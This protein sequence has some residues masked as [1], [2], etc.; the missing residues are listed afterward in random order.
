MKIRFVL[1]CVVL[2]L[3]AQ[4]PQVTAQNFIGTNAP[5]AGTN[6]N[7]NVGVAATNLSLVISNSANTYS[8][9]LLKRGG[10]PTDTDFDFVSRVSGRTNHINL[11]LPEF[12]TPTNYGL[13]VLTPGTSTTH[14]FNVR[15]TT[16]RTDLRSAAYPALKPLAFSTTGTLTN[17]GGGH[18]HYFQVDVPTNLSTGWRIVV[19]A[20][21][22][23]NPDV[24][25]RRNE[26]PTTGTYDKGSISQTIDTITF[27]DAEATAGTY[28]IGVF[29]PAAAPGNTTYT[30][31]TEANYLTTLTW[32]PGATH[33]GTQIFT[34][35]SPTGGDYFFKI[36]TQ[37]SAV[38]AWRTALNVISGEADVYLR[39]GAFEPNPDSYSRSSTRVGS[40]GF[41]LHSTEYTAA[42]T[43]YIAVRATPGAQWRLMTGDVFVQQLGT[44]AADAS[45]GSG[46]VPIGPEGIRFFRTT[47]TVDTLAWR[48]WLNGATN[49]I[50]IE[51]TAV[52]H[53][54][55][56]SW[57]DLHQVRQ[58]LIVP[59]YLVG[60]D[61]YFLCVPGN[62]GTVINLDSR[63][64]GITDVPFIASTNFTVTG[65]GYVTY[66]I[67]VP[68][69]QIAWLSAVAPS[70]GNANLSLRRDSVPNE[71][72]NDAYSE[73]AGTVTDS[74]SLVPP[75]LSDGTFYVTIWGDA[76][77]TCTFT[78]G[79]PVITPVSYV[80]TILN[81]DVNRVGWRY[82]VVSNIAE[83]LG[84]LGWDLV[85]SNQPPGTEIAL[86]QNAVPG[87]WN[88][89]G[90]DG[91]SSGTQ[92][93]L[94]QSGPDGFIQRP[95]HQ[96]DIYYIGVYH[97]STA[98]GP[99][100]L[101]LRQLSA[102]DL[103]FDNASLSRT[104]ILGTRWQFF[105][106]IVP[107]P[108]TAGLG[109][110]IRLNS[111]TTGQPQLVIARDVLPV[112]L[113][114]SGW[115]FPQHSLT[116]PSGNHLAASTDWTR[117]SYDSSGTINEDG[118]I[119]QVGMN[120]PLEP[121]TYYVGVRAPNGN[122]PMTYSLLSRGIGGGFTI[123][124]TPLAF[125][126]GS[127]TNNSLAARQ[128]AYY[129]VTIASNTPSWKVRLR[130]TSGESLLLALRNAL[131]GVMSSA[132]VA[133]DNADG[134]KM[135]KLGNEH[136]L[137]LPPNGQSSL[138]AGTY[139][140]AV[141]SEGQNPGDNTIGT[142]TSAY[143]LTSLGP[144]PVAN[145][146]TLSVADLTQG[147]ALQGGEAA[148]YQ[149]TVAGGVPAFEVTLEN[150]TGNP[151]VNLLAGTNLPFAPDAYGGEGG[152]NG[153]NIDEFIV[154]TVNPPT[155]GVYSLIV[156]AAY[157]N[158]GY[159]NAT[160][161]L[162]VHRVNPPV[163][164]ADGGL[165]PIANQGGG[166]YRY[167][168]VDI[169]AGVLGWDLRLT[170][171][172]TVASPGDNN[173]RILVRRDL[174]PEGSGNFHWIFP[175]N[176]TEW[177]SGY[178]WGSYTDW[179][180]RGYDFTGLTN[181]I[182][183]IF[184]VGT[185]RPLEAGT[186]YVGVINF[187]PNPTNTISYT[188]SSR[189]IGTNTTIRVTDLAFN[190][191]SATT[192]HP[193]R[194]VA[195]Y[196]VNIP[197]N[198][199]SWKVRVSTNNGEALLLVLKGAIP[200]FASRED[201]VGGAG[202]SG[203][204]MQK[205]GNEYF[206][207]LP[208]QGDTNLPAGTYYL[209]VV[210]EGR[211]PPS[212]NNVGTNTTS[213]TITSLGTMPVV[214]LGTAGGADLVQAGALPGGDLAAYQFTVPPGT[215][216]LEV[217]LE[218]RTGTPFMA[219]VAGDRLPAPYDSYGAEGGQSSSVVTG[220]EL[221]N[222]A[223]PAPGVF[224][225]LVKATS[226]GGYPDA[227]YTV[228]VVSGGAA[229]LAFDGGTLSVTNQE[230]DTLRYFLVTVPP[231]AA[232]WSL[233]LINVPSDGGEP[234]MI[235]SR[236]VLPD[237][238]AGNTP[239]LYPQ[240]DTVWHPGY[241]WRLGSDWTG[242]NHSSD[243]QVQVGQV[244]AVG[245][246]GPLSPGQYYVGV[247]NYSQDIPMTYTIQSRGIGAGYT[248]PIT[249]LAFSNG[250]AN[251]PALAPREAAYFRVT[252][253]SNAPSWKVRLNATAGE[254]LL[255]INQGRIPTHAAGDYE[256]VSP[257]AGKTM[258]S[259]GNEHFFYRPAGGT[260]NL[261]A[262]DYFLAVVSEGNN[263]ANSTLIGT[264]NISATL[265]SEGPAPVTQLGT[266]TGADLV[267]PGALEG[268]ESR[269]YQFT[270]PPDKLGFNIRLEN[271]VGHPLFFFRLGTELPA[272]SGYYYGEDGGYNAGTITDPAYYPV[273]GPTP[274]VYSLVVKAETLGG[275]FPNASYTLRIAE[276]PITNLNF[277]S[278]LNTNGLSNVAT[279]LLAENERRYYRVQVPATN[280]GQ[281]VL[282]WR[283]Q[284]DWTSGRADIRVRKDLLPTDGLL[285]M[286]F[287][288]GG[289]AAIV[290]PMLTPGTWYVEVKGNGSTAYTLTNSQLLIERPAWNLPMLGQLANT[291]G[292]THPNFADTGVGTNGVPLPGDQG[293]DLARGSFHYYTV[294]VPATNGGL[295]RVFLEAISG[296]PDLYA[297]VGNPP[298]LSHYGSDGG[299]FG[300][301]LYDR[302][303]TA[304][305]TE[306][307]N[308][309]PIQGRY[310]RW[311]PPGTWY[312]AVYADGNSNVRYR[313]RLSVGDVQ[314]LTLSGGNL[315]NQT[316]AA[317]DWR[318]YRVQIPLNS[319]RSWNVTFSQVVGDVLMHVRD[320][321]PPG[322]RES[323]GYYVS[324]S[325]DDKNHGPYPIVDSPGTTNFACPP[326]RPGNAYYLGFRAVNDATFSVS[327]AISGG[328]IDVTNTIAFYGGTTTNNLPPNGV[329]KYRIDVPG[330]ATRWKHRSTNA[331][332][333]LLH[334]DQGSYPTLTSADH[335]RSSGN[336]NAT[337]NQALSTNGWPWQP[338]H[339]YFL[340]VTNTSGITQP[341]YFA[342]DGK[343]CATDDDDNDSLLD[344]WELTYWQY[345]YNHD[346]DDDPDLDGSNNL[347]E[348]NDGTNP[349]NAASFLA[350]LVI[351]AAAGT[352]SR[353]PNQNS[354]VPGTPVTLT[355]TPGPGGSFFGWSGD[356][357]GTNNPLVLV[358]NTHKTVTAL[359]GVN[360]SL[361][362]ADY[363]FQ[364]SLTS[365]VGTAPALQN[366][367][368]G[369]AF[370]TDTVD[371]FSRTVYRWP[372]HN[373][374]LL[375]PAS[376]VI[377]SN[378]WSM[379][380]LFRFDDVSGY[381]RVLDTKNPP[382]ETG[383]YIFDGNLNFY[384]LGSGSGSPI[385]AN[386]YVQVVLT[387]DEAKVIR[388]YVNGVLQFTTSAD[389]ANEGLLAGSPQTLRFFV[390]NA[391][392][393]GAGA[394]ARIRLYDG[395]IQPGQVT[396][397]DRLP[398]I[399][400]GGP[401][402][403]L[404]N[405][406]FTANGRAYF[407]I[408]GTVG[409]TFVIERNT[410][411]ATL[412][413]TTL[414]NVTSFS[415]S[416][417]FTSP[418]PP[419]PQQYFRA[420]VP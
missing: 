167:F 23:G 254:S 394:V 46:A 239:W 83:Q 337:L 177:T 374:L 387:R 170:N 361:P 418:P 397:L 32:D 66:R 419:L 224:S 247:I 50:L 211:N 181:E 96:A 391:G 335:W 249:P 383:L 93:H 142:G 310:E 17:G 368:A 264:G 301:Y 356:A 265:T 90:N 29:L 350:Q 14:T 299:Y 187:N 351:N 98:L 79:N 263:P 195:Y 51:K 366:V 256:V 151:I 358:M 77:Y 346:S 277:D 154:S 45:S 376:G 192:N 215:L 119:L 380:F 75:T 155:N 6:F 40:D 62:P 2:L 110:D 122:A 113:N 186:Y 347:T 48:L 329:L 270:I 241:Q 235:V 53:P 163:L 94:D 212:A 180:G 216:N 233:R 292:V 378:V 200:S 144:L 268:G 336:A 317:G 252:V 60:G 354:Y 134:L 54:G 138:I 55:S 328:N 176:H 345:T 97:P 355:A 132:L 298:T 114:S 276:A 26:L 193:P 57:Y 129:A 3:V 312:F 121:G 363:R 400:P 218:N 395:V 207:L 160:Y 365:S 69:Q 314:N 370:Q 173:H 108:A 408:I 5:G 245:M 183:R 76:N 71:G 203:R 102:T 64:Q 63:K 91:G 238:A 70:S 65:Y 190:G 82:F 343:N 236:D 404:L 324:W 156:K 375:S 278:A 294:N 27:T 8:Y 403:R 179:T 244:F 208:P 327:S 127:H 261:P 125:N 221:I 229:N 325:D 414:S 300:P 323:A 52:P 95:G 243:G 84:S 10:T 369:N 150:R 364:N 198:T 92:G 234:Q 169:P 16:N 157:G 275:D 175:Q 246:N 153:G 213:F 35:N 237:G 342:M 80:S 128:V 202:A 399:A 146:G 266:L 319:P 117:R 318:Y 7:F 13:R 126:G 196:R 166:S 240:Y 227:T 159:S 184:A 306:Y 231:N 105:K 330:D 165:A 398:G 24:F 390:D 340:V 143:E 149:F 86:R 217:R 124:V 85:L 377:S 333:V 43:W 413:W 210:S 411:L 320:V 305:G 135:Q 139:Y 326:L 401:V 38:G 396:Q 338:G 341:F 410:N 171:I 204:K 288:T 389:T 259:S 220:P 412:N 344:C 118:R 257:G 253:P 402:L 136:F 9:L 161:T 262:G 185:G 37:S 281:A 359:F 73:V 258:R 1:H 225:L 420:R 18:W 33:T 416:M 348:F 291:A 39:Q 67:Q 321:V 226:A 373:G 140:L 133:S 61:S 311:L 273:P 47:T 295:V 322:D 72:N 406:G 242:R 331:D 28:F 307:A 162:R 271:R 141:V 164:M 230:P 131:P 20:T 199:P 78:S 88:Y 116:W 68:I 120:R 371:G 197:S 148:A 282:G 392:E 248:I 31:S 385:A 81:A 280:R 15:L 123:P 205:A 316:I 232:G 11:Q 353:N 287:V 58:M 223:N 130:T 214:N 99:F 279:N 21:G 158:N 112:A 297:R 289:E 219:L 381:R 415:G 182:D 272:Q 87:R 417:N 4:V 101:L 349:T 106:V 59:N 308:W 388:G 379:V 309:V 44:L 34:N 334:L 111:V 168:R 152:A 293:I 74:I 384:P 189:L 178:Q 303:L 22:A 25:V 269:A 255:A 367:G 393:D 296:D 115:T 283:L 352:V 382:S 145:L 12:S 267:H 250:V 251:I 172:S 260:T 407:S 42:Q 372:V 100:S 285:L 107:A 339:S 284:A 49:D 357:S 194:E 109:W 206:T 286:P 147:G 302:Y 137:L 362:N 313:M 209:A 360:L 41:V 228:R 174:L 30:L 222:V 103:S 274:G 409:A 191:G 332:T 188:L 104:N 405:P 19:S 304:T 56:S 290:S 315:N 36:V 201:G 89:R 386:T